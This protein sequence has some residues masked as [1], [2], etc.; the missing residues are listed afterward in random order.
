MRLGH[1]CREPWPSAGGAAVRGRRSRDRGRTGRGGAQ[2]CSPRRRIEEHPPSQVIACARQA[3]RPPGSP[4]GCPRWL[5]PGSPWREAVPVVEI[6]AG[7][8]LPALV[9]RDVV[10][11]VGVHEVE[12]LA[13]GVLPA[14]LALMLGDDGGLRRALDGAEAEYCIRNN[15]ICAN[16]P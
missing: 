13:G 3:H 1:L 6:I 9:A 2:A 8:V 11:A 4:H 7:G 10:L 16:F 5:T 14:P 15:E 12:I